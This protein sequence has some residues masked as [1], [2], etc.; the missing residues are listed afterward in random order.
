MSVTP[1]S[2][3]ENAKL[4]TIRNENTY[5]EQLADLQKFI[6]ALTKLNETLQNKKI[7]KFIDAIKTDIDELKKQSD[8]ICQKM[9][10]D[11]FNGFIEAFNDQQMLDKLKQH[12]RNYSIGYQKTVKMWNEIA[13]IP[14]VSTIEKNVKTENKANQQQKID[15]LSKEQKALNANKGIMTVATALG[16]IELL[17]VP[18]QRCM[19]YSMTFKDTM[20]DPDDKSDPLQQ[21]YDATKNLAQ[22]VNAEEKAPSLFERLKTAIDA[23]KT[24]KQTAINDSPSAEKLLAKR[25]TEITNSHQAQQKIES[26]AATPTVDSPQSTL[27]FESS[28]TASATDA[29]QHVHGKRHHHHKS[30]DNAH[31]RRHKHHRPRT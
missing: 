15:A 25:L 24:T 29:T 31:H 18:Q 13:N 30:S 2:K 23:P 19:R 28:R 8:V 3:Q 26:T 9:S 27:S 7:K 4:E 17:G 14:E 22:H 12:F 16:L 20:N 11:G 1:N 10:A 21:C 5:N 6:D